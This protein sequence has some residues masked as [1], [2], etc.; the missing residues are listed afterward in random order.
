MRAP[1]VIDAIVADTERPALESAADQLREC[2]HAA[3]DDDWPVT[4]RFC[5]TLDA[6]DA[7]ARPTVVVASLLPELDATR[8]S[9][10]ATE[11][12]WR[13]QLSSLPQEP[14]PLLL[15]CTVFRFVSESYS[16]SPDVRQATRERIRRLNLLAID[17]SHDTGAGVVDID[18][19]FS[20]LGARPLATDHRLTGRIAAEIA[21]HAIVARI[22]GAG[23][24]DLIPPDVQERAAQFQG[25]LRD[26]EAFVARRME[27]PPATRGARLHARGDAPLGPPG[28]H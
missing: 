26:A 28:G 15:L 21:A 6:V 23:L 11:A 4:L 13:A 19:A 17:L 16:D 9:L 27:H 22:L 18:R 3:T 7:H 12:R 8:E 5:A 24:D 14:R 25:P 10:A 1:L 2:L 20:H